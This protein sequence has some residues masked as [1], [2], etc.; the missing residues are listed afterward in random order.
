MVT[1]EYIEPCAGEGLTTIAPIIYV[2]IRTWF[3]K[4]IF[5]ELRYSCKITE[6]NLCLGVFCVRIEI[7]IYSI[8]WPRW[9]FTQIYCVKDFCMLIEFHACNWISLRKQIRRHLIPS[10]RTPKDHHGSLK[11][12]HRR[13]RRSIC[14][15]KTNLES[16][17][18]KC[19]MLKGIICVIFVGRWW[20]HLYLYMHD[21]H[22][23]IETLY[24]CILYEWY[25]YNLSQYLH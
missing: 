16:V 19:H 6:Q 5:N 22:S 21:V 23:Q 17:S 14:V 7:V 8:W 15:C 20:T 24:Y 13:R 1:P 18:R 9:A 4:F 12:E 10:V 3:R 25:V 11:L 2:R